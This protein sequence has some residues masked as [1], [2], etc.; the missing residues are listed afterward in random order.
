MYFLIA[1]YSFFEEEKKVVEFYKYKR[2]VSKQHN[3]HLGFFELGGG[4]QFAYLG[5][6]RTCFTTR[7]NLLGRTN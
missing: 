3:V 1:G 6:V 5:G 2:K 7:C 4:L